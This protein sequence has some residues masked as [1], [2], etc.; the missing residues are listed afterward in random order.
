VDIMILILL[1]G[2]GV[3][4]YFIPGIVA[5]LRDHHNCVAIWMLNIF[6]GWTFLGWVGALVWACTSPPVQK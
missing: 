5:S 2:V 3:F 6:A 4:V 1:I